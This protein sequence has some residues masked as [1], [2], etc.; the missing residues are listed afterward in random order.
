MILQLYGRPVT[1]LLDSGSTIILARLTVLLHDC[2][3]EGQL[4]ATC[5][6]R[7]IR[8]VLAVAVQ[9]GHHKGECRVTV[10]VID[11]LPVPLLVG[12]DLSGFQRT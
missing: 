3:L 10:G 1:A 4:A 9:L 2:L 6:H 12:H 7:D 8:E 5:M 11:E